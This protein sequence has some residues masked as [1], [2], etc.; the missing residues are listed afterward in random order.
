MTR[1]QMPSARVPC[2]HCEGRGWR[3]DPVKLGIELRRRRLESS[4]SVRELA[5]KAN[6]SST[7][8][9]DI[10]NGNRAPSKEVL[11]RLLEH[12]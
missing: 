8:L 1:F 12:V 4:F 3:I 11:E 10:E 7:H 9:S 5:R 6:I 2:T